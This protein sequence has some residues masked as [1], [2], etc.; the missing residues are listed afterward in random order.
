ME[1]VTAEL[2]NIPTCFYGLP[3]VSLKTEQCLQ[4][5]NHFVIK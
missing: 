4:P 5:M 2:V 1:S 3:L